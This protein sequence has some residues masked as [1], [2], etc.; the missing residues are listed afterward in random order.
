MNIAKAYNRGMPE[1]STRVWEITPKGESLELHLPD[2]S[3]LDSVTRQLPQGFYSTFR[4]FDGGKRA[5]G[6]RTHLQRLYHPAELQQIEPAVPAKI[7][8]HHLAE[9]LD[10]YSDEA[11]VRVILA[12][13]GKVYFA[14]SHLKP[15]PPEVYLQGVKVVT[16]DMQRQNPR[17]KSTAFISASRSTRAQIADSEFFEA[18]LVRGGFIVEG[19]T[20]N[21]FY[22]KGGKLGTA[23]DDI[24]LGVTRGIVLRVARGSGL[25]IVYQPLKREK[26]PEISEAF[27]TSS[28]RGVVPIV[29][30]DGTAVGD[31]RPGSATKRVMDLYNHFVRNYSELIFDSST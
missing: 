29:K 12:S 26:V 1:N 18:L 6:L 16:T 13:D 28:S 22:I 15:L 7:L 2:T 4:T 19:M 9:L 5:L 23:R 31:G 3:N 24:L 8:R 10:E 14:L 11:R 20:S 25:D 27:L 17:L 21:F 30:I